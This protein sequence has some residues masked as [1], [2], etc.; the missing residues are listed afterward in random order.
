MIIPIQREH[1][2]SPLAHRDFGADPRQFRDL[3]RYP[4][5]RRRAGFPAFEVREHV[6]ILAATRPSP[7]VGPDAEPLSQEFRVSSQTMG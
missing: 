5:C 4:S 3:C 1:V 2:G 6:L 7:R